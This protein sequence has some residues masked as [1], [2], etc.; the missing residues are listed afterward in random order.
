MWGEPQKWPNFSVT[1]ETVKHPVD[2]EAE[3][4]SHDEGRTSSDRGMPR[5]QFIHLSQAE[6]RKAIAED[7][8]AR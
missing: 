5:P 2:R 3:N 8:G 7:A 6:V 1:R 4:V